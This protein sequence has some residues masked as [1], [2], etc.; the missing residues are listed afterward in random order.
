M[1]QRLQIDAAFGLGMHENI[2]DQLAR[3]E[4]PARADQGQAFHALGM[5][6]REFCGK[7]AADT[8]TDEIE[9]IEA[10]RVERFEIV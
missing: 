7:P 4:K 10:E 9:A 1:A 8:M 5:A 3:D 6:H 2:A